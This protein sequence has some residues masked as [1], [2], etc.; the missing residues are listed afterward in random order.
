M[1]TS[2]LAFASLALIAVAS[3]AVLTIGERDATPADAAQSRPISDGAE[4]A[5]GAGT[6]DLTITSITF[7]PKDPPC[8]G[9]AL[10]V[11]VANIGDGDAGSFV[12]GVNLF[13]LGVSG[14]AANTSTTVM[15]SL[16][17][18]GDVTAT[19]D[20]NGVITESD[21]SNNSLT[22]PPFMTPAPQ[23]T[24]VPPT[25]TPVPDSD[26]DGDGVGDPI[27]N[28]PENANADQENNDRNFIDNSPP[29]SMAVDDGTLAMSDTTGDACDADD[30]NDGLIDT[31]EVYNPCEGLPP[32]C[33]PSP[34]YGSGTYPHIADTD[35]DRFLDGV[36]CNHGSSPATSGSRPPITVCGPEGDADGD[37]ISDRIEYCFYGTDR[38]VA[39]SDGD[40]TKDGCEAA[41][42][43]IDTIINPGD[44][45]MLASAIANPTFRTKN[46][47]VNKDGAWNP[48]DQGIVASLRVPFG[49]CP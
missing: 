11:E 37:K 19:A 6:A 23:P 49:Q 27:D 13:A 25:A 33:V 44:M 12:V 7:G 21:E 3:A 17:T 34:C 36:E 9:A 43:N 39:D 29:F 48:A 47:D 14:L 46:V 16:S 15:M 32:P 5:S 45:G 28:C 31:Q 38:L 18:V 41:S 8:S 42:F 35:G 24:C 1:R 40:G 10:F 30:D 22:V 4:P 20:A 2:L 26:G